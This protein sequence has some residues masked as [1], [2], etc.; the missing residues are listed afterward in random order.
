V[1]RRY[2][3][4]HSWHWQLVE[5]VEKCHAPASL[6]ERKYLCTP[7][8]GNCVVDVS[9]RRWICIPCQD[10]K[11]DSS[12]VRPVAQPFCLLCYP[13]SLEWP[14]DANWYFVSKVTCYHEIFLEKLKQATNTIPI[15]TVSC[16]VSNIWNGHL[17]NTNLHGFCRTQIVWHFISKLVFHSVILAVTLR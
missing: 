8:V 16:N 10:S 2:N 12:A 6:P 4:T 15:C 7:W 13:S 14:V 11:Y 3:S 1:L 17:P 9:W 5:V